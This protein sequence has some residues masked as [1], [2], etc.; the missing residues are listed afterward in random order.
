VLPGPREAGRYRDG[1]FTLAFGLVQLL[2]LALLVL[3]GWALID[4]ATRP[5]QAFVVAGKQTKQIWLVILGVCLLLSLVG[6]GGILGFFGFLI[7]VAAI[8]YLVDVRPAV[9]EIRPGGPWG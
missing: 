4:A 6:V 2:N 9:R 5:A 3:V 1:M 7:A 8:V